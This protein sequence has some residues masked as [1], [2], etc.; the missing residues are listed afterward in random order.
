MKTVEAQDFAA[1]I[2]RYLEDSL[3]ERIVITQSGKPCAIVHG[4]DYDCEQLGLINSPEFWALIEE[5]RREPTI[6]WEVAK[7]RL[8]SLDN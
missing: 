4:L 2:N 3:C 5:S 6:P 1:A 7:E 8:E